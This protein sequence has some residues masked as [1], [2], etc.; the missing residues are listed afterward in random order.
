MK[1]TIMGS[2]A[3][4]AV[5]SLWCDC[6][7]CRQARR[8][9]GRDIRRR[10]GYYLDD[11]TLIDFGPDIF[12][13]SVEFGVDW[14]K[15]KR[16]IITHQH[17]DHLQPTEI[18]WRRRGFAKDP[19]PLVIYGSPEIEPYFLDVM[20]AINPA[21]KLESLPG[22][23][24]RTVPVGEPVM[25]DDLEIFSIPAAHGAK[26]SRNYLL[27]RGGKSLL[28]AHD[29]GFWSEEAWAVM[30]GRSADAVIFDGTCALVYPDLERGHM[31]AN[32]GVRFRDELVKR[33]MLKPDGR[34]IVN[35]FSH[36]GN[37]LQSELEAFFTPHG[38]E[39]A[40]DGKV[41]EL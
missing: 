25:A 5:P 36:N 12:W 15:L 10:T 1:I 6:E 32:T 29:T 26:D 35:H 22:T 19:K 16:I 14:T 7:C 28:I 20:L 3:A 34:A 18:S 11:D 24:F 4:E 8:N 41:V 27:T 39:V 21:F 30:A 23:T 37:S 33:G 40:Y 13:Q 17:D 38:I 9:G 31:G 2:A